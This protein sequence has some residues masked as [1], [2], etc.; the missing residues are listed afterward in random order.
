[1]RSFLISLHSKHITQEFLLH[2]NDI[3][4]FLVTRPIAF[5]LNHVFIIYS[6]AFFK[7]Y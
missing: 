4:I 3:I 6:S 5:Y 2:D 1:M 7:L